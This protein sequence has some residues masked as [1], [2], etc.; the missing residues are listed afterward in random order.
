MQLSW[1]QQHPWAV[2][3][4]KG[5]ARQA[6]RVSVE[7]Q[8]IRS[9][10]KLRHVISVG[11]GSWSWINAANNFAK[12]RSMNKALRC[13]RTGRESI[14]GTVRPG[15]TD[16]SRNSQRVR[17]R[18][19]VHLQAVASG[20][21][22]SELYIFQP[23]LFLSSHTACKQQSAGAGVCPRPNTALL[24][25]LAVRTT[26]LM[27]TKLYSPKTTAFSR[28]L[29]PCNAPVDWAHKIKIQHCMQTSCAFCR[30]S[31]NQ[32]RFPCYLIHFALIK[33][34]F[35]HEGNSSPLWER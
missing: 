17:V 15:S 31:A 24:S 32:I 35:R 11:L 26:C 12:F 19:E 33:A 16:D 14:P 22:C 30:R 34:K 21:F 10:A 4:G 25:S 1:V 9:G 27:R 18:S 3:G 20:W 23:V 13:S 28:A 7:I 2:K 6:R 8:I 29:R 5:N